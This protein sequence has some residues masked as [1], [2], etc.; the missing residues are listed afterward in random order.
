[1]SM[2]RYTDTISDTGSCTVT[3]AMLLP[4]SSSASSTYVLTRLSALILCTH[5]AQRAPHAA[6]AARQHCRAR[7]HSAWERT[8]TSGAVVTME[9]KCSMHTST[10]SSPKND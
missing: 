6:H 5:T 7:Q 9:C 2:S 3:V 1:M 4:S 8:R 10:F